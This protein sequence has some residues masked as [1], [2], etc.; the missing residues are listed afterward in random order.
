M[1][2]FEN[3]VQEEDLQEKNKTFALQPLTNT[4][5]LF[6][7]DCLRQGIIWLVRFRE[8]TALGDDDRFEVITCPDERNRDLW[9]VGG[10]VLPD[11]TLYDG[12]AA[13][14]LEPWW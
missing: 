3:T 11:C 13:I 10:H 5:F 1:G 14:W 2:K 12:G 8:A 9:S 7:L 6:T 4:P